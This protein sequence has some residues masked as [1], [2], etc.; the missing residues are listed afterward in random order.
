M[1][2]SE[3]LKS[4]LELPAETE[5]VEFKEAKNGYD[6]TKLGRYF[7]ALSN[8]ANL[9]RHSNAWLVFGVNNHRQVVGTKYRSNRP[10]LDS[11]KEE[12]ANKI[13]HRIT[14]V[15]IHEVAHQNGRVI[16]FQIPAAP[17][18]L[19]VAFEG[20]YYGRDGEALSPLNLEEIERIRAQATQEDWSAAVV[21]GAGLDD[22]DAEAL[23]VARK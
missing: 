8:E 11:L 1:H 22:L 20:H 17:K 19:P 21:P 7:S 2:A 5:T 16:L 3:K 23:V 13:S 12:I 15:E 4:L 6:F 18:G 14:F 9:N 10:E